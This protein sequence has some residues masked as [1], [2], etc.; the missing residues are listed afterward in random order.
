M[1]VIL[2][3]NY[4]SFTYNLVHM[5]K[6]VLVPGDRLEVVQNDRI[7]LEQVDDYDKIIL[8]PG[9]GLPE[10]AGSLMPLV[11]RWAGIK[12]LLGVCLGHQALGQVYGAKLRNPRK[13]FH[14]VRS[15][16]SL[17]KKNYLFAGLADEIEAGR[18]HSWLV[19]QDDFPDS[20]EV[21]AISD[22]GQI[23]GLSHRKHDAHGLQFHP[24]SILTPAGQA[25]L[26][27]FLYREG[28]AW[29]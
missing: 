16:V 23:M 2:L 14:G 27:N 10:E 8:S 17:V 21:T 20:L 15:R 3:D 4:D 19:D 1:N 22:D 13:V 28:G 7:E 24:E 25:I 12:P 9:P 5:I 11:E 18:Y 26:A 29:A 6:E